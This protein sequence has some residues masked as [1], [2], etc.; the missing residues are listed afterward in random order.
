MRSAWRE[1]SREVP[2][3]A[4]RSGDGYYW[5]DGGVWRLMP[6]APAAAETHTET[7]TMATFEAEAPP[8]PA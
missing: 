7:E 4:L 2:P 8:E 3:S 6:E 1:S 5:W